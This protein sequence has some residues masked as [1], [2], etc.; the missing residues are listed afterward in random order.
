[1]EKTVETEEKKAVA[2]QEGLDYEAVLAQKDAELAKVREERENYR[3]GMLKAKGKLPDEYQTD[4]D[5]HET[6]EEM[7]RR[8]TREELLNT[9][10]AQLQAEKDDALKAVLKRNK[11]LEVALKNRGQIADTSASGSNEDKFEVKADSYFSK[12]QIAA[13]RAKGWDDKKIEQ[14]KQNMQKGTQ[15]PK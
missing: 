10:E 2:S 1:M 5:T 6:S 15:A 4:D 9:K 8:V 7:V 11:E 3:K 14:A 13:L 12:E